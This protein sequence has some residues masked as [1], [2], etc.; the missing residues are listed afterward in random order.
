M[1]IL[2]L[3]LV[4]VIL[5]YFLIFGVR[6][7]NNRVYLQDMSVEELN[8]AVYTHKMATKRKGGR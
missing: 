1:D 7:K 8:K 6:K 2:S 4:W 3:L 5:V